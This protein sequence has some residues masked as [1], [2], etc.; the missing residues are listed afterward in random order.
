VGVTYHS[1]NDLLRL[2]DEGHDGSSVAN[3]SDA[4]DSDIESPVCFHVGDYDSLESAFAV[5]ALEDLVEPLALLLGA[6]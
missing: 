5:F 6:D 4:F 2:V 3:A 1:R